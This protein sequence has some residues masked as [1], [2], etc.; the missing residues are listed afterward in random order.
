MGCGASKPEVQSNGHSAGNAREAP[1]V[2]APSPDETY[3]FSS[4]AQSPKHTVKMS[5]SCENLA[6][7]Q[8]MG[9][10][11]PDP[12]AALYVADSRGHWEQVSNTE[13]VP[14]TRDP[15]FTQA[16]YCTFQ[17]ERP[18]RLKAVML[19][20]TSEGSTQNLGEAEFTLRELVTARGNRLQLPLQDGAL[21]ANC[22][23]I[24]QDCSALNS[25]VVA[26]LGISGVQAGASGDLVFLRA[27][28]EDMRNSGVGMQTEAKA[29]GGRL[30]WLVEACVRELCGSNHATPL[31]LEAWRYSKDQ[32]TLIGS[33]G[34]TLQALE[35]AP[36]DG[37]RLQLSG[38][39]E[40]G[41]ELTVIELSVR[42]R[43]SF[44]DYMAGG[45]EIQCML[46]VD[47]SSSNAPIDDPSSFHF[48]GA[49]GQ[50]A[51]VYERS[52]AAFGA[53]MQFYDPLRS[54]PLWG[55]GDQ[56]RNKC[57]ALNGQQFQPEVK[58]LRG[59]LRTYRKALHRATFKG[60]ALFTPVVQAARDLVEQLSLVQHRYFL[61]VILTTSTGDDL[62]EFR[63]ALT[64]A[65]G[66]LALSV[67][68]VGIG[69]KDFAP[70]KKATI[71]R[72]GVETMS[73]M[74]NGRRVS[75]NSLDTRNMAQF[76]SLDPKSG[77]NYDA[78]AEEVLAKIPGQFMTYF[79]KRGIIPKT[80]SSD[81]VQQS[82]AHIAR[83]RS[84]EP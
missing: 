51:S 19:S 23:L 5:L 82:K 52:M 67:I 33:V 8:S 12:F 60:P 64:G 54:F 75:R 44:L 45:C 27:V 14:N 35:E 49:D 53:I 30:T 57:W 76:I 74:S 42:R 73:S 22:T 40:T 28:K 66:E 46:A 17:F 61:L 84:H 6:V 55:F 78:A 58:G 24:A 63:A 48:A 79:H 39:K 50:S 70:L 62:E 29:A 59:L 65:A 18:Q 68:V 9:S 43:L 56:G 37:V 34:T 80:F 21:D 1:L 71:D 41:V 72:T 77:I 31:K 32:C 38:G 83:A 47:F 13:V 7:S 25:E 26:N 20:K 2:R 69:S 15:D 36:S 4:A 16:L 10:Q 11:P 3:N 81:L